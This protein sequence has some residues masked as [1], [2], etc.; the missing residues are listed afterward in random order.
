[1]AD[2]VLHATVA[3]LYAQALIAITRADHELGPEEGDRLQA[4][5]DARTGEPVS[6]EDLLLADPIGPRALAAVISGSGG[7]FRGGMHVKDL[8]AMLVADAVQIVMSKGH[9]SEGEGLLTIRF[10]I[11]LG[12]TSADIARIA[13]QLRLWLDAS[14]DQA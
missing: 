4:I 3:P 1:M 2:T 6:I 12:C 14:T 8:G 11:A 13:P 9:I 5:L 7:P 10:A